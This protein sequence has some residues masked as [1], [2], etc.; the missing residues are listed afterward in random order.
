[1]SNTGI[2][3]TLAGVGSFRQELQNLIVLGKQYDQVMKQATASTKAFQQALGKGLGSRNNFIFGGNQTIDQ[4]VTKNLQQAGKQI[5]QNIAQGVKEG[6]KELQREISGMKERT[7]SSIVDL[8][9]RLGF[10]GF[11]FTALGSIFGGALALSAREA[12]EFESSITTVI[13]RLDRTDPLFSSFKASISK[14]IRALGTDAFIN[15]QVNVLAGLENS[16]NQLAQISALGSQLGVPIKNLEEFTK[17][18]GEFS[19]ANQELSSEEASTFFAR[20]A[21]IVFPQ[22]ATTEQ[23]RGLANDLVFLSNTMASTAPEIANQA[24]RLAAIG[25]QIGFTPS[26]TLGLSSVLAS[27]GVKPEAG[28]TA[29][30]QL[31]D[32]IFESIADINTVSVTGA[33]RNAKAQE[34]LNEKL[35]ERQK[36][37][38]EIATAEETLSRTTRPALFA[39]RQFDII[40][41][42]GELDAL[43][44]EIAKI[45]SGI[46]SNLAQG[47]I[48]VT[49]ASPE[50]KF[51][52]QLLGITPQALSDLFTNT[53]AQGTSLLIQA[54]GKAENRSELVKW[55]ENLGITGV[56]AKQV[57]AGLAEAGLLLDDAF[58]DANEAFEDTTYLT[59]IAE[60]RFNTTEAQLNLLANAFRD[61]QIEIGDKLLPT[62]KDAISIFFLPLFDVLKELSPQILEITVVF[63]GLTL[64]AGALFTALSFLVNPITLIIGALGALSVAFV[65]NFDSISATLIEVFPA[66]QKIVDIINDIRNASDFDILVALGLKKPDGTTPETIL[67]PF[68]SGGFSSGELIKPFSGNSRVDF[69]R[70]FFPEISQ[71]DLVNTVLPEFDKINQ[72]TEDNIYSI[73]AGQPVKIPLNLEFQPTFEGEIIGKSGKSGYGGTSGFISEFAGEQTD[74]G[75]TISEQIGDKIENLVPEILQT[76]G[77]EDTFLMINDLAEGVGKFLETVIGGGL[78]LAY[79][80]FLPVLS[81][82]VGFVGG[83]LAGSIITQIGR[84]METIASLLNSL[85]SGNFDLTSAI[86]TFGQE[87]VDKIINPAAEGFTKGLTTALG[88]S[89]VGL[90]TDE[91]AKKLAL[92]ISLKL[93]PSELITAFSTLMVQ[94]TNTLVNTDFYKFFEALGVVARVHPETIP[95]DTEAI[96]GGQIQGAP[97]SQQAV[98]LG[99]SSANQGFLDKIFSFGQSITDGLSTGMTNE[100][101]LSSL[102]TSLLVVTD[103]ILDGLTNSNGLDSQSPS[104]KTM[105]IGFDAI[106]GLRIG[107]ED[108]IDLILSPIQMIIDRVD[109]LSMAFDNLAIHAGI[110]LLTVNMLTNT[111]LNP[112]IIVF[113]RLTIASQNF[114]KVLAG[115]AGTLGLINTIFPVAYLAG[116]V[117]G[118]LPH[119]EAGGSFGKGSFVEV[120]ENGLPFE[121]LQSGDRKFLLLNQDANIYSPRGIGGFGLSAPNISGGGN[122]SISI[123]NLSINID[124]AQSASKVAEE[125]IENI[126]SVAKIN[127]IRQIQK[128]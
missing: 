9:R 111:F 110:S 77:S 37:T 13:Q 86:E 25:E 100:A 19:I 5:P 22:G 116:V 12:I 126:R 31:F 71:S 59:E 67:S 127:N 120:L 113:D 78:Q 88:E 36:L 18:I 73:F 93:D 14:D 81:G 10:I 52:A 107:M 42:R 35:T 103:R 117:A 101:N 43:N 51:L 115:I 56:R 41:Q 63:A 45:Q 108:N 39:E 90:S 89:F 122:S 123:G 57:I 38:L 20:F 60:E 128:L 40:Q 15:G 11:Q 94:L 83:L 23:F 69:L 8:S 53:P 49:N 112:L 47:T 72:F 121:A 105:A 33:Q 58:K 55:L 84:I 4:S 106:D 95:T 87:T 79:E 6:D 46:S 114:E 28:G 118:A 96:I 125:V 17:V 30:I 109:L 32:K 104:R 68:T 7:L 74:V 64:G 85:A 54:F 50:A 76:L 21:N 34:D 48:S 119:A 99:Y 26:E 66:F 29:T 98:S 44:A 24:L 102:D 16:Q 91:F 70:T 75:K 124:G 1:M 82:I 2:N 80:N 97:T 65:Q 27:I 62:I 3:F 61:L 92:V